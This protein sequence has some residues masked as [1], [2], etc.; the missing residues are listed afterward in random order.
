RAR[1]AALAASRETATETGAVPVGAQAASPHPSQRQRVL[2]RE[3]V[4]FKPPAGLD[5]VEDRAATFA[6]AMA[7]VAPKEKIA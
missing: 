1:E 2:G 5:E 7:L 4:K 6:N 3:R